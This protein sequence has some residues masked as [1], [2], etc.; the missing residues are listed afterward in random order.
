VKTPLVRVDA[1]HVGEAPSTRDAVDVVMNDDVLV[2]G[3]VA[4]V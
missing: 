3:D 1:L 2:V 4:R